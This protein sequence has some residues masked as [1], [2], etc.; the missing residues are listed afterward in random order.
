MPSDGLYPFRWLCMKLK[1]TGV[2]KGH[3]AK[4]NWQTKE[5]TR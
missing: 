4:K 5:P 1:L 2:H 3:A